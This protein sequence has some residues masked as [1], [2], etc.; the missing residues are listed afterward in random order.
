M[1]ERMH[2]KIG[3]KRHFSRIT[4]ASFTS[5]LSSG[6]NLAFLFQWPSILIPQ[7]S[8]LSLSLPLH[9]VVILLPLFLCFLSDYNIQNSQTERMWLNCFVTITSRSS[10]LGVCPCWFFA[11]PFNKSCS[12]IQSKIPFCLRCDSCFSYSWN[13]SQMWNQRNGSVLFRVSKSV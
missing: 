1:V 5:N 6:I 7:L 9:S 10:P 8:S 4:D 12:W 3:S 11:F 13:H 2:K